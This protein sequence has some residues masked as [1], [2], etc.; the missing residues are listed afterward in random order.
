MQHYNEGVL[1]LCVINIQELMDC[2][3][4]IK[5]LFLKRLVCIDI[6]LEIYNYLR[7]GQGR[8]SFIGMSGSRMLFP[9]NSGFW[10]IN[11]EISELNY[12]MIRDAIL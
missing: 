3:F 11:F 5:L 4:Y 1:H 9:E 10:H 2:E 7:E 12:I 8:R 6:R